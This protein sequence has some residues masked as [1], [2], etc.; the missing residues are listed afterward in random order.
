[1]GRR[2]AIVRRR[3]EWQKRIERWKDS[4]LSAEQFQ[5]PG[6]GERR[7]K[8]QRRIDSAQTLEASESEQVVAASARRI[9]KT[10]VYGVVGILILFARI[11]AEREGFEPSVRL[12]CPLRAVLALRAARFLP[13]PNSVLALRAARGMEGG[14]R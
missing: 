14:R 7:V 1:M 2:P 9:V 13:P 6:D 5:P 8:W 11:V 12:G 10:I 3:D 4:G